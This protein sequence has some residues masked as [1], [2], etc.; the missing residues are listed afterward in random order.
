[1]SEFRTRHLGLASFL[2]F[3]GEQHV[4]TTR[5]ATGCVFHFVNSGNCQRLC[6]EFFSP[7]GAA[8][9]DAR[10]LLDCQRH[11]KATVAQAL[12]SPD[13]SWL[14]SPSGGER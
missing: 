10:A 13:G 6:D 7:Q 1:V 2:R 12:S 4:A 3:C 11:A 14:S 9:S 5:T 8:A